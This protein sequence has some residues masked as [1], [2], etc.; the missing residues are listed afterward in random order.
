MA[1][2]F[3][4]QAFVSKLKEEME[5][6]RLRKYTNLSIEPYC[7]VHL[8]ARLFRVDSWTSVEYQNLDDAHVADAN[9]WKDIWFCLMPGCVRCYRPW[10][11]Y[12]VNEPGMR[13]RNSESQRCNHED[14]PCMYIGKVGTSR[15][16]MCPKY[17]CRRAGPVVAA[18]VVD[19]QVS[20]PVDPLAG[21]KKDA[22]KQAYEMQVFTKFAGVCGF[23]IDPGSAVNGPQFHPD[24]YCTVA[25]EPYH[26]ELGR[27]VNATV[28]EKLNPNRRKQ[29]RGFTFDQ[30]E[31]FQGITDDKATKSY[32]TN[33]APVDLILHFDLLFG[34]SSVAEDMCRK[35]EDRLRA[36]VV[37]GPFKR[38]WVFDEVNLRVLSQH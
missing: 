17:K 3:D 8:G 15:Q 22:R 7:D 33:G 9:P 5:D 27:I 11:G 19:I 13:F 6:I 23:S 29:E 38:V 2:T 4:A 16:W 34:S 25:G 31:P 36:L 30:S 28:A 32:I 18:N 12:H 21:L 35:H 26:F 24:I 20:L 10:Y 37:S 14:V 1:A